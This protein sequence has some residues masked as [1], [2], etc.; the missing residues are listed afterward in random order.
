MHRTPNNNKVHIIKEWICISNMRPLNAHRM[1]KS[2]AAMMHT[3]MFDLLFI[4]MLNIFGCQ[5]TIMHITSVQRRETRNDT[6][7]YY[8]VNSVAFTHN[9]DVGSV[10]FLNGDIRKQLHLG[11]F[12]TPL[13]ISMLVYAVLY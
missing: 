9:I 8:C 5:T 13:S 1:R 7:Q 11:N 3:N 12:L 2:C 4:V 6:V 10:A